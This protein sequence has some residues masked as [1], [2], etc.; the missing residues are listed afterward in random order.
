MHR[1]AIVSDQAERLAVFGQECS[2]RARGQASAEPLPG[3]AR[4]VSASGTHDLQQPR[5]L[6]LFI[7]AHVERAMRIARHPGHESV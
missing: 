4:R 6:L 1:T 5:A 3:G 2:A 7:Q